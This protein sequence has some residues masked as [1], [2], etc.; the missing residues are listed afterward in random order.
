MAIGRA[1][2]AHEEQQPVT[3]SGAY[4]VNLTQILAIN[5]RL[6]ASLL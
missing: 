1:M 3:D 5:A 2:V 4:K 6:T